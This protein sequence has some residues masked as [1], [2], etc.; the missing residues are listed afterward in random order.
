MK[1]ALFWIAVVAAGAAV[2]WWFQ[3]RPQ[4]VR[5][6]VYFVGTVDG[7]G[8]VVP[9]QR[10]ARGRG[11]E[12]ILS[13]AFNALLAGPNTEEQARGLGT[14]IP[15]GTRLRGLAVREGVAVVDLSDAVAAGGGSSSMQGRLWQIVYTGTQYPGIQQVR[16]LIEGAER[17]ALGGEGVLIDRPIARPPSFPRF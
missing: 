6:T 12:Q 15:R 1:R 2:L 9:V 14:E 7:E 3:V 11:P 13:R 16:I 17:Q 8:T 4:E 10:T 5:V